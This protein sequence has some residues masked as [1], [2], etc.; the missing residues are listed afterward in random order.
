MDIF[1]EYCNRIYFKDAIF[2]VYGF[3]T[4][5]SEEKVTQP[6]IEYN[7]NYL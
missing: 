1:T 4:T 5:A 3:T 2:K 7:V 6:S